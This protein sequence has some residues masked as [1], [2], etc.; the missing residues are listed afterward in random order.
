MAVAAMALSPC[1]ADDAAS[2]PR[3]ETYAGADYD[4]RAASLYTSTVWSVFSPVNQE[5]LRLKLDG[6]ANVYGNTNASVFSSSFA[7]ADLKG[8]GDA[9]VGYQFSR[10]PVWIKVYAGAAYQAQ[11]QLFYDVGYDGDQIVQQKTWG[12]AAAIQTYWQVSDQL[13]SSFSASWLQPDNA[14]CVY[15]RL[16][17]EIYRSE[18]GVKISAGGEG[19]LSV[20]S[21]DL[22]KEGR[23][24]DLYNNYVRG[25]ALINLRYGAND[26]SLSGGLS[27]G[28]SH[29]N[30]DEA[31]HP[32]ATIS[33]GRQF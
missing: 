22:F 18:G 16:A 9:L 8:I 33:Y 11:T 13:W 12:G 30:G 10:G 3:L 17:Y 15:S 14:T 1:K 32:Y 27:G 29:A 4:G 24:L 19:S 21:A 26:L 7:A 5:G 2:G 6:L 31:T 28:M 23:A 20:D 25:G